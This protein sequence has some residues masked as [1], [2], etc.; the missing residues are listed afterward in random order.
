MLGDERAGFDDDIVNVL[1]HFEAFVEIFA[2]EAEALAEAMK[3]TTSKLRP[4]PTSQSSRWQ[5]W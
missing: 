3:L 1:E 5:A 2:F 4:S